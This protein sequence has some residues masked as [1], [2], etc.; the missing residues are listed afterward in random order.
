MPNRFTKKKEN[1]FLLLLTILFLILSF[2][3]LKDLLSLIVYS[4]IIS[5]FSFS[6]YKFY[7]KKIQSDRISAISTLA[8][9]TILLI[10]PFSLFSYFLVLSFI[11]IIITYQ[12]YIQNPQILNSIVLKIIEQIT[13]SPILS[14]INF[15][16][17]LNIIIKYIMSFSTGFFTAIPIFLFDFF[18]IMFLSYYILINNKNI[19]KV[20]NEY[21]PLSLR[22]QNEMLRNIE[23]NV[24]VLFKG[25]FLTGLIQTLVSII[26]YFIFGVPNILILS[27]LTLIASLLP[28]IGTPLI[29]VP[30]GIYL[31]IVG[32]QVAGIGLL[33]YGTLVITMIDNFVRPWLMSNKETLS[34]ALV[35]IGFIGGLLAFGIS[36]IIL[37]PLIISISTILLR[38]LKEIYEIPEN[39]N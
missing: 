4:M 35:F 7:N 25:Y 6:L 29:W 23:K 36:G 28:Y 33:I 14:S 2:I 31:L 32:K 19:F 18:I 5:Y 20:I 21:A 27:F 9:I 37:G 38:Y 3:I 39:K 30:I 10:I 26:G 12:I 15:S 22:K 24:R 16:G 8:T 11:K 17:F 34:P 1:I 13:S